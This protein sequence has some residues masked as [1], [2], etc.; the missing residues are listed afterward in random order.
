M[1]V[2]A[3]SCVVVFFFSREPGLN[4]QEYGAKDREI[5]TEI[6]LDAAKGLKTVS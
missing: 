1:V 3:S 5:L 4:L 2:A 6:L